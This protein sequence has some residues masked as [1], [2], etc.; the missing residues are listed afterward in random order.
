MLGVLAVLPRRCTRHA[1]CLDKR[2]DRGNDKAAL[3][4]SAAKKH[5]EEPGTVI[6]GGFG[7]RLFHG[8]DFDLDV[9]SLADQ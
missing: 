2:R 7:C 9:D 1:V 8:F 6:L 5:M 4:F 3:L